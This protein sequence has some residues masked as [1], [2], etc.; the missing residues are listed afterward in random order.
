[1]LWPDPAQRDRLVEIRDNL[2]AR[3]AE[4][5]REGWLG[6][7]EGLQVSL[8][9][10]EEKLTQLDRRPSRVVVDLGVPVITAPSAP[11]QHRP[12]ERT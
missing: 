11:R 5:E 12:E 3:I 6:E 8:A 7:M 9:G 1:M 10:A 2:L 4:A